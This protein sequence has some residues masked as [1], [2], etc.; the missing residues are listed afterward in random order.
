MYHSAQEIKKHYLALA[1]ICL[2]FI[3]VSAVLQATNGIEWASFGIIGVDD[4]EVWRLLT[5]HLIHADWQHYA[6]NM[7]GLSLCMVVFR[8]DLKAFHWI[9]SFI[10]IAT[11]SSICMYYAYFSY[12]RYIGFSDVL[13]GWIL[14]GALAIAHKEP[15]FSAM[16]FIL[17]WLK[18]A[19]EN[20]EMPFFT[21][22][23]TGSGN[24]ARESHIYGA[25]GGIVYSILFIDKFRTSCLNILRLNK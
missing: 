3:A 1:L 14:V 7:L 21:T 25:V 2:A 16:I 22:Y 18:I 6:M 10:F 9:T 8:D 20:M 23:G 11:F 17:F 24:V 5:G 15:K 12:E 4:G 13:H 19:E